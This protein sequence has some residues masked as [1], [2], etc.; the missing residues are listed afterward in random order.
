MFTCQPTAAHNHDCLEI[1]MRLPSHLLVERLDGSRVDAGTGVFLLR[2]RRLP[3]GLH[4]M[5]RS[6]C[7]LARHWRQTENQCKSQRKH[8]RSHTTTIRR[9]AVLVP[10]R[11]R[12]EKWVFHSKVGTRT[13]SQ[14]AGNLRASEVTRAALLRKTRGRNL[15][16]LPRPAMMVHPG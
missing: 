13:R 14:L 8:A 2:P 15:S 12:G 16:R 5:W 9:R 3:F 4:L 11:K 7:C 10:C 6:S 1:V